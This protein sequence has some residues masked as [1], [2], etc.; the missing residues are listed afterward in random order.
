MNADRAEAAFWAAFLRNRNVEAGTAADGA[1]PVAGGYA[2]SV[3][4]TSYQM[5]LA[6]GSTRPL[7]SEDLEVLGAFYGARDVPVRIELREEHLDRDYELF[8]RSGYA[9][10]AEPVA[11]LE[12]N[13]GPQP[14][15]PGIAVDVTG[16]R[17]GWAA[18]LVGRADA[19]DADAA[20]Q[21]RSAQ[22]S[23]AAASALF[24][25]RL[26]NAVAG[27]GALGIAGDLAFLY[28]GAV[29]PEFRRRGVHRALLAARLAYAA[30]RG[31]ARAAMKALAASPSERS[32]LRAGFVRT[33]TLR[34]AHG[35]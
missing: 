31:A 28:S 10:E 24:V 5:A 32:A 18:L 8:E 20:L 4:G 1:V 22:V 27:V 35:N 3:A 6:A 14:P 7:T 26:D 25:A 19:N 16:D 2:I 11:L 30:R 17:A 13:A 23:A 12:A 15:V 34:R 21:L 33:A 29:L 9:I